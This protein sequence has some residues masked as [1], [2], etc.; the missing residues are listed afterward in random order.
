MLVVEG[1]HVAALGE[2]R[3]ARRGRCGRRTGRRRR[4]ARRRPSGVGAEHTQRLAEGDRGL[5]G[6]PGQLAATDHADDGQTG[7]GIHSAASLAGGDGTGGPPHPVRGCGGLV[8]HRRATAGR[9]GLR[10][11]NRPLTDKT[12]ADVRGGT[13][14]DHRT[15][16]QQRHPVWSGAPATTTAPGGAY[17]RA[18]STSGS[19]SR[20]VVTTATSYGPES[21]ASP[22]VA[23]YP[24]NRACLPTIGATVAE[25]LL[26]H[27]PVARLTGQRRVRHQP[28]DQRRQPGRG[29]VVGRVRRPGDRAA[30]RRR[31]CRRSRH[32]PAAKCASATSSSSPARVSQRPSPVSW[33][34][35]QNASATAP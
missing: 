33:C 4:P 31:R 35:A 32:R 24:A 34:S 18:A 10:P 26:R 25:R 30:R 1:D 2:G 21:N 7:T 9:S 13:A 16:R 12:P 20:V 19:P 5:V 22:T 8:G 27:L 28:G 29:G 11:T 3:A 23:A 15:V 14:V 6:H 17:R